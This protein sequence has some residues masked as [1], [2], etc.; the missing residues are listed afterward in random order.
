[1]HGMLKSSAAKGRCLPVLTMPAP[2]SWPGPLG[3]QLHWSSWLSHMH[4][5]RPH[6]WLLLAESITC[7]AGSILDL[8]WR[9]VQGSLESSLLSA[10]TPRHVGPLPVKLPLPFPPNPQSELVGFPDPRLTI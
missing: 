8:L 2:T 9:P 6:P 4:I 10:S 3:L 7:G 1:M 5:A